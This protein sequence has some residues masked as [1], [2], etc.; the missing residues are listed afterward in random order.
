M[1]K[2][3]PVTVTVVAT[4]GPAQRLVEIRLIRWLSFVT[5]RGGG[6]GG[7]VFFILVTLKHFLNAGNDGTDGGDDNGV[8]S[9]DDRLNDVD[10]LHGKSLDFLQSIFDLFTPGPVRPVEQFSPTRCKWRR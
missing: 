6:A 5:G 8:P 1:I 3:L 7:E 4:P 2:S 10:V 9:R